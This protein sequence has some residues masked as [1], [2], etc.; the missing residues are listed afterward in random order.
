MKILFVR[1]G[2]SVANA[3]LIV[4]TPETLLTQAGIDQAH[5]TGQKLRSEHVTAIVCSP[6]IRARQ[7]AEAIAEELGMSTSDITVI[8]ELGERR[9]GELEG[10]PK[11][12]DT[13]YFY[14]NDAESG[15]ETHDE[16][17][18]RLIVAVDKVKSVAESTPDTTVVVGHAT[19]GFFF[20]QVA[21]G[22]RTYAEC[23]T[24]FRIG[25]AEP[26]EVELGK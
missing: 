26:I 4:G 17:L 13:A 18:K 16:L 7:T 20:L 24:Y 5:V 6:F 8:D 22:H 3:N 19:S 23:D 10:Q 25:N 15:F 14:E 1:H 11:K 21:K 9:M 2:Q 12:Y